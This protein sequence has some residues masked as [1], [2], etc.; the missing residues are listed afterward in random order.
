M[1]KIYLL[2]FVMGF[3]ENL[4]QY[5][6]ERCSS[7]VTI[8]RDHHYQ[9]N[10]SNASFQGYYGLP[11]SDINDSMF[12]LRCEGGVK[13]SPKTPESNLVAQVKDQG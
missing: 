2:Y 1:T 6:F 13:H 8:S 3:L 11:R 4:R 12:V 5:C 10:H 9:F 7:S